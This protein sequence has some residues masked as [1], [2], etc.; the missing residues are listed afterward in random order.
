MWN[1]MVT[2]KAWW[3][4][5]HGE[6]MVNRSDLMMPMPSGWI[7]SYFFRYF[8][9]VEERSQWSQ[10]PGRR[11][12][13]LSQV[14]R[15]DEMWRDE[16]TELTELRLVKVPTNHRCAPLPFTCSPAASHCATCTSGARQVRTRRFPPVVFGRGETSS[17]LH[18]EITCVQD[19]HQMLHELKY[20][21]KM[22]ENPLLYVGHWIDMSRILSVTGGTHW[23][24]SLGREFTSATR[25]AGEF[26]RWLQ[27]GF[28]AIDGERN[29][30]GNL[31]VS[32]NSVPLNP[33][34]NDHYPY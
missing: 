28:S 2:V 15:F 16:L 27:G 4:K 21:W 22:I 31:G 7:W 25:V 29:P 6:S 34:V 13:G 10:C 26:A 17:G 33:M 19:I 9:Q 32:E 18:V 30:Q 12:S 3:M 1:S 23:A 11:H 14:T 8:K 20:D 5:F 24:G